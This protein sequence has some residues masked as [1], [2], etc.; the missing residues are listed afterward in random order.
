MLCLIFGLK[1]V[2]F[3]SRLEICLFEFWIVV[4]E[5]L[6][7]VF[8][9]VDFKVLLFFV[10]VEVLIIFFNECFS[11]WIFEFVFILMLDSW[12]LVKRGWDRVNVVCS[13]NIL[14]MFWC[15]LFWV[16]VK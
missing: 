9:V 3:N 14:R 15:K 12:V 7:I 11:I 6:Y 8:V 13:F 5:K 10:I 4:L 16:M 1:N 2:D